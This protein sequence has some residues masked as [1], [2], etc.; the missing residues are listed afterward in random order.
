[1]SSTIPSDRRGALSFLTRQ[2]RES[3]LR[4]AAT[5][6]ERISWQTSQHVL[7][8][9]WDDNENDHSDQTILYGCQSCGCLIHPGY[10]G[11]GLRVARGNKDSKSRTVRRREQKK[12]RKEA[13][14]EQK[15]PSDSNRPKVSPADHLR[16]KLLLL[17]DQHNAILDRHHLLIRCGRCRLAVR[18]K[19]LKREQ[20]PAKS[21]QAN[22]KSKRKQDGMPSASKME[23]NFVKLPAVLTPA[24]TLL[25][26]NHSKKKKKKKKEPP[27][28]SLMSF[29]NSLND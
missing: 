6:D 4:L 1:M 26:Q 11:T 20:S 5:C 7:D 9:L 24:P 3:L 12:R 25:E 21:M 13:L 2:Y 22:M 19:G 18:C 27:K 29:L 17:E 23:S 10:M 16:V 8:K 14:V 15:Q 28:S